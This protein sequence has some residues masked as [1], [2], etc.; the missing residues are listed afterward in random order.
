MQPWL[1]QVVIRRIRTRYEAIVRVQ[2]W[3][4]EALHYH[5]RGSKKGSDVLNL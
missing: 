4:W 1:V 3:F 5:F 2:R